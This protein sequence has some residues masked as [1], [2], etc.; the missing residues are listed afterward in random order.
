MM[1]IGASPGNDVFCGSG[2][3]T[4]Y[5]SGHQP[6]LRFVTSKTRVAEPYPA[7]SMTV[8]ERASSLMSSADPTMY[9]AT[10]S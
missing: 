6:F 1:L 5:E 10:A 4:T 8:A 9:G 7:T 2:S 3:H